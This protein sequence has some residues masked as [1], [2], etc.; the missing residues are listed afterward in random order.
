MYCPECGKEH[1]PDAKYCSSCG[2]PLHTDINNDSIVD[3]N[4]LNEEA[5][6]SEINNSTVVKSPS[7]AAVLSFL[8]F[9]AGQVYN[10]Q[11][12]PAVLLL[13]ASFLGALVTNFYNLIFGLIIRIVVL[14]VGVV[15]AYSTA[16]KMNSGSITPT[17]YKNS[18]I[19]IYV[20]LFLGLV[21][22]PPVVA[23]ALTAKVY[24]SA[25]VILDDNL[26]NTFTYVY[27][28][29]YSD[30]D[31]Y[32]L[33]YTLLTTATNVGYVDAHN[34]RATIYFYSPRDGALLLSKNIAFEDLHP[35]GQTT[36]HIPIT[37]RAQNLNDF[38]RLYEYGPLVK[39]VVT[40]VEN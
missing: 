24:V 30:I 27:G 39:V 37:L 14:L 3:Q 28:G 9:G 2:F 34:I 19:V 4:V 38:K 25:N 7:T 21:L 22:A 31:D 20:C 6:Q 18:H 36:Q 5:K 40:N 32:A 12:V 26:Q 17:P 33:N 16:K 29:F 10:W 8:F 1:P 13:V 35:K 11:L 15:H 23:D